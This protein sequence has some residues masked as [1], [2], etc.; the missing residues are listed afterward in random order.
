MSKA[1][2]ENISS[3]SKWSENRT[4]PAT[5]E[6]LLILC[7]KF[8]QFE[9]PV[10]VFLQAVAIAAYDCASAF[11]YADNYLTVLKK[12]KKPKNPLLKW[13]HKHEFENN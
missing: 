9:V 13:K 2:A 5:D 1:F 3:Y 12:E 6:D 4:S 10:N 8:S 7:E 11:R